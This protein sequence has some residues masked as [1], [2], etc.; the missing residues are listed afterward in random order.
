[1]GNLECVDAAH[2]SRCHHQLG[3]LKQRHAAALKV[4]AA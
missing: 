3:L 2:S 4:Q 1:L